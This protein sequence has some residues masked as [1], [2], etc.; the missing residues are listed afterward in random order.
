MPIS[1]NLN[2][3]A[4]SIV[5]A[6][7]SAYTVVDLTER[8][9]KAQRWGLVGWL[10]G[11]SI[12]LGVGIWSMHFVGMLALHLPV[13][14]RYDNLI[15][16]ISILPAIFASGL[17]LFITSRKT[18]PLPNLIGA[19]LLMGLGITAMHYTGM[20]AMRLPAAMHY[21]PLLVGLSAEI[22]V[23]VS[24]VALWL[25]H[26]LQNRDSNVWWHKMG[27]AVLMG[28]A[29]PAMHYTGMAAVGFSAV[30]SLHQAAF[31]SNTAWLASLISAM[32]FAVLG[33]T[34]LV[35]SETKVIDRTK[36]LTDTLQQLQE[37]QL[38]LIQ[39]EKMSSLGQ[40]VAGVAHEINNPVNF[41]HGNITY[42]DGY[43]QD[44]L[45]VVRAYQSAYP[46][47]PQD[48]Q[49][50]LDEVDFSFLSKDVVR[51]IQSMQ[52]GTDRIRQIVLSL[53]GFSRMDE[54]GFK[55]AD[56][57]EGID[58]TLLILQHRL[59]SQ[60]ESP[61]IAVVKDYGQLPPVECYPG[62]LNQ[63][64]M[65]LLAN[66]ID[67]LEEASEVKPRTIWISTCVT[68]TDR[69]Q[70]IVSDNGRG[71]PEA[72]RS[73]IF[74]PFF[75]TKEGDKGTGIGL[76]ISY[77]IVVEKHHGKLWCDSTPGEGSKF[78]IELPIHQP[79]Q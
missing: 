34:L 77:Q 70:V 65:N 12:A 27:A 42:L 64:F 48:V 1:Y 51:L 73:R 30:E 39:S 46:N 19:S 6:I 79:S 58:D 35:A 22:A 37:S 61:A 67:V 11:G 24:L 20:A 52:M 69:V 4:L 49:T 38:Q 50:I 15:V 55:A 7:C 78:V 29:I 43:T 8:V 32:T 59:E 68:A 16:F 17:A 56:L 54:S 57:H 9:A 23:G 66:A 47:P 31:I 71:M 13:P 74:D 2:L 36:D 76:S 60:S 5:I 26:G 25:T 18:L 28:V 45:K 53:R 21:N 62:Q 14:I 3:V 75:T 41:I 33:L 44:F 63:V 40:L 10:L 72:V